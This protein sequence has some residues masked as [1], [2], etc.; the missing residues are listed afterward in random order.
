VSEAS[1]TPGPAW[2]RR[3]AA[4][5]A[6]AAEPAAPAV[7]VLIPT[8][9]GGA[10]LAVT[11]AGLA[12]QDDPPFRVIVS[13]QTEHGATA[14]PSVATIARV[15]SAQGRDVEFH[16][17]PE[18][19]GLAE[20]RQWLLDRSSAPHV[21][22]LDDDVW[23]EPGALARLDTALGELGCGFVG[24]AVQGL[25]FLG[26]DRPQERARLELWG[27]GG[28]RPERVRRGEPAFERWPLHNAANLAHEAAARGLRGDERIPY[29]VAWIGG[30]VL[31]RRDALIAAGGFDFWQRLPPTHAG[32]DVA[33]QWRVMEREGGAGILPSGAVHLEA[34]TTVRD[35][36]VEAADVVFGR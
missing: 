22:F 9:R 35:R 21:L 29:K 3:P 30:C 15:L 20:Q 5:W 34:P 13:D 17:R 6:R 4:A 2:S 25:S 24:F 26:D 8:A 23:L 7:D 14:A 12:A 16:R 33:A 18:R 10:E 28:V 32:E 19:R 27:E 1:G 31:Y 36:R 11:L